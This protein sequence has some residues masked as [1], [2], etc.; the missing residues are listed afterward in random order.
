MN[1]RISQ[2]A[3]LLDASKPGKLKSRKK[4]L[5]MIGLILNNLAFCIKKRLDKHYMRKM[6]YIIF[7]LFLIIVNKIYYPAFI[8]FLFCSTFAEPFYEI[9]HMQDQNREMGSRMCFIMAST[10]RILLHNTIY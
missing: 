9:I 1:L 10:A 7:T 5:N 4:K 2:N 6:I 3:I 8:S